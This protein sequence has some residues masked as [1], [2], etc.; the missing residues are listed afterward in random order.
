MNISAITDIGKMR[1][2]NQDAYFASRD[3]DFPLFLVADGMGGHK[4]GELASKM[5]VDIV[6]KEFKKD[7]NLL[8]SKDDII[9][10]INK[11]INKANEKIHLKSSE[12]DQCSGMGTTMTLSYILKDKLYIGHVGDS[13]AYF[14]KNG[15]ISQITEDH[16]LV[17]ELIKNGSITSEEAKSH[18]QRNL[19]TRAVG[20]SRTIEI[21]ILEK[22][23]N[24][25]DILLLCS[26]GLSNMLTEKEILR[27]ALEAKDMEYACK[28]LVSQAKI[29]GGPDNITVI[30]IK[31]E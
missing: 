26:D 10:V 31:F 24:K 3:I 25:G 28:T 21:D 2:N 29:N 14:I 19:I 4:A 9:T 22:D 12:D 8:V 15:T 6:T 13:R 7:K 17:N 11:S 1:A 27:I 18:P 30:A 5:T 20:S 23:Y 16:S